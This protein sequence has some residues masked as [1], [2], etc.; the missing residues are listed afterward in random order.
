MSATFQ[1]RLRSFLSQTLFNTQSTRAYFEPLAENWIPSYSLLHPKAQII[2]VDIERN[3]ILHLYLRP[4]FMWR[5][6]APGQYV[7]LGVEINGSIKKRIFS[8]SS[9]GNQFR[10]EGIIRLSIQKQKNGQV[11]PFLFEGLKVGTYVQLG[12]ASGQ[13]ILPEIE[14]KSLL[15]I[16]G[17]VGITPFMSMLSSIQGDRAI[18][19]LYYANSVHPHILREELERLPSNIQVRMIYSDREGRLSTEHLQRYCPDFSERNIMICGPSE[20]EAAVRTTL[21][22]QG[23]EQRAISSE[24]F[25]A[26]AC[27]A[28]SIGLVEEVRISLSRSYQEFKAA[29]NKSILEIL[30]SKGL[31]PRF[32]CRMG[33]CNECSCKKISG[34]VINRKDN[35]LS[36]AGEEFIR[37]C[38]A[39]PAGDL[40]LEF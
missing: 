8:I 28:P 30:E 7:E 35:T 27:H 25:S 23:I 4:N 6:F 11:T 16:A 37:I 36:H 26:A 5:G 18:T 40:V 1:E 9:S 14:K 24:S 3:D 38:S 31:N 32:G 17:G 39:M 13:F 15:L 10:T 19:V 29:N 2:R 33:I 22:E 20:M 34:T 12:R 21:L